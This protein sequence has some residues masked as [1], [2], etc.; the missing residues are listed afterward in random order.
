MTLVELIPLAGFGLG[1]WAGL[2]GRLHRF[3]PVAATVAFAIGIIAATIAP[4]L[5]SL[6][7]WAGVAAGPLYLLLQ[8]LPHRRDRQ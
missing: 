6:W 1:A 7:T 5:Q 3:V 8:L 2:T 4:E